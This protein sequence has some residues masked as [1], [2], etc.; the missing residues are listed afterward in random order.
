MEVHLRE[1]GDEDE[2]HPQAEQEDKE[3]EVHHH[4]HGPPDLDD[5]SSLPESYHL[6]GQP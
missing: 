5:V 2:V 4:E 3:D 6:A 1:E